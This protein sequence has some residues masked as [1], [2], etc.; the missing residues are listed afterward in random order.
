MPNSF[1]TQDQLTILFAHVAY[2]MAPSFAARNVPI[3]HSQAWSVEET[4]AKLG[5][6]DVLVVSG[7]WQN[8]MLDLAPN[9]RYIQSIGAGYDQ[10]PLDELRSRGIRLANASGV[11]KNA[12]SEHAIALILAFTRQLH[13]G[14]DN[15]KA[16]TWRGMIADIPKRE[17]ELGE[18]T[19]LIFGMGDIGSRVAKIAK[20]FDMHV[21]AVKR[22]PA[23]AK[24]P[25]DEVHPTDEW[26]NLVPRADFVV[27]TCPLTPETTNI[28]D[29][30]VLQA[31]KPSAYL[32]N[33]AR[34]GCVD[35]DALIEALRTGAIAGAGIDVTVEE[36]LAAESPLW[37]MGNVI[38]TPH[39]GGETQ[40]YEDNVLDILIENLERLWRD[41][42][43][44][45]NQIV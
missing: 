37:D 12:V 36:P 42:T 1:P 13:T 8:D 21:V 45:R 38:V 2:Q 28:V 44:L 35:Q 20:A 41:E 7:F 16:H 5:D 27:L 32:I 43:D 6:A 11:N 30:S 14:R 3:D 15:Q 31:M 25:A 18:K 17:D 24:G 40:K 23:T 9:L 26:M 29:R 33:V 10:F 22:N 39:T 34:G 19:L 4:K